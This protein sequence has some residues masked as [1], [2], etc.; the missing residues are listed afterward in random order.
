LPPASLGGGV[1]LQ[2]D[3]SDDP[4]I[5]GYN[6]HYGGASGKYT[7]FVQVGSDTSITIPD[8]IDGQ[9]YYITVASFDVT[10]LESE[11]ATE[12]VYNV[13]VTS[14]AAPYAEIAGTYTGLYFKADEDV[15]PDG[16]ALSLVVSPRGTYSA[17]LG[18]PGAQYKFSGKIDAV[19]RSQV[20]LG[21]KNQG[22][23][24]L[25]IQLGFGGLA[26][27]LWGTVSRTRRSASLAGERSPVYSKSNPCPYSKM[28]TI[29]IPGDTTN[30]G[31]PSGPGIGTLIVSP[32]GVASFSGLL[33]DGTKLTRSAGITMHGHFP[34]Y[35]A[36]YSNQGLLVGWLSF[37]EFNISELNGSLSWIR[38]ASAKASMFRAGFATDADVMGCVFFPPANS[39]VV[40]GANDVTCN[41]SG[42]ATPADFSFP[43]VFDNSGRLTAPTANGFSLKFT[44]AK[45]TFTGAIKDPYQGRPFKFNGVAFQKYNAAYGLLVGT[46]ATSELSISP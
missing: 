26:G 13:P 15:L 6:L 11:Y 27:K 32:T 22:P 29:V 3:P 9:T 2:W 10:G 44:K 21:S 5:V 33:G 31:I 30:P 12:L 19:G 25:T 36:P 39:R 4:A 45:G 46:N 35:A 23:I 18:N 14:R 17:S 42:R 1:T 24:T 16:G 37:E 28:Y 20:V 43:A 41:V 34:F 40:S 7:Q 8:L 38:P